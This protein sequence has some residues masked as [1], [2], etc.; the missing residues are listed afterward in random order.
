VADTP[1]KILLFTS[2]K[3]PLMVRPAKKSIRPPQ[4]QIWKKCV[5]S[6]IASENISLI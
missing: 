5:H 6:N 4:E 1:G 3:N 2:W